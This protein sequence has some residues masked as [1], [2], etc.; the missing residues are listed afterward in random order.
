[1]NAAS[2]EIS[3][4]KR[5][6]AVECAASN[7][8]ECSAIASNTGCVSE[9]ELAITL[10]ISAVAVCCSRASFN[11]LPR[12][13]TDERFDRMA[14]GAMRRLVLPGLRP[15]GELALRGFVALVLSLVLDARAISAPKV[16][17]AIL[18]GQTFV[19]EGV[20]RARIVLC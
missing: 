8:F 20:E 17:R 19:L 11:S 9:G 5:Y 2:S 1:M 12:F 10:R 6:T 13:E 16:N 15:F 7:R 14:V 4:M 18:S 3:S